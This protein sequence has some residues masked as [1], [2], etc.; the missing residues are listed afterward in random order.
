PA[1]APAATDT[2][3]LHDALPIYAQGGAVTRSEQAARREAA[4]APADDPVRA[5][6]AGIGEI[7]RTVDA[8][9]ARVSEAEGRVGERRRDFAARS[10]EHTSELQSRVALVCRLL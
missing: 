1:T 3:P 2:R 5:A 8:L 7:A 9:R 10:E 6:L 4:A